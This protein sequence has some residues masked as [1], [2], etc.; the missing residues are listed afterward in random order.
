[1]CSVVCVLLSSLAFTLFLPFMFFRDHAIVRIVRYVF[2]NY[3]NGLRLDVQ[4][5]LVG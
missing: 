4:L 3:N 5:G 2:Y 1:L